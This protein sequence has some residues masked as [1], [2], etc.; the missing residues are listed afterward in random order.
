MP[1]GNYC[2][3]TG[4]IG[5]VRAGSQR[6]CNNVFIQNIGILFAAFALT[7]MAQADE[8]FR[9]IKVKAE[10]FTNVTVTTVT[11]TDIYFTHARGMASAK[12]KDLD[13]DLQKHFN[14]DAAKSSDIERAQR[15]A[16]A[17]FHAKLATAK[18]PV[19]KPALAAEQRRDQAAGE[20]F[21]APKLYARSVRGQPAPQFAVEKWLTDPP[22]TNGKFVLVDFWATW[23]GPCRGSIPELN[24]FYAKYKDR[25]AIIG[26][27]GETE[28]AVRKMTS[29][30]I[31][32]TV[33]IDTQER[34]DR[35]LEIKGIPHCILIDPTGIVRYE[36]MPQYLDDEKIEHFLDKYSR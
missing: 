25:L 9:T 6:F 28:A 31:D 4:V 30:H 34:M 22:D 23:C 1:T 8:S 24:A 26:V 5:G 32:Y 3:S 36:G 12:L 15:Q 13:P 20:D 33:A 35:E 27:S 16:T 14:Y 18:A 29:P 10:V 21:V 7:L 17:D 19:Q 2:G 11:A